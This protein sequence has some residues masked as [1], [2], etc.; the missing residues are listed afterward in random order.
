MA[1]QLATVAESILDQRP[2]PAY[3]DPQSRRRGRLQFAISVWE[4]RRREGERMV[5]DADEALA[6]LRRELD[7]EVAGR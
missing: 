6:A 5:A 4:H 3:A 7:G 1:D 2:T